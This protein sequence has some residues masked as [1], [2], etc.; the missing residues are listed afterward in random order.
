M[1]TRKDAGRYSGVRENESRT[2]N[3]GV[4]RDGNFRGRQIRNP[5]PYTGADGKGYDLNEG[6]IGVN[7][8]PKKLG[9][10]K[11]PSEPK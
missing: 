4:F 6:P 11:L 5:I 7:K 9:P 1:R 10:Q 2:T 8:E 3:P